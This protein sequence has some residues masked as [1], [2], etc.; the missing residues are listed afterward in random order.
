MSAFNRERTQARELLLKVGGVASRLETAELLATRAMALDPADADALALA[1]EADTR[2]ISGTI[3]QS[4][5]RIERARARAAKAVN[6]A[7]TAF[8]PRL[9]QAVF[10]VY[11][12]GQPMANNAEPDLIA[13]HAARPNEPRVLKTLAAL[14]RS[15]GRP[16][17]A[18]PYCD[19]WERIPGGAA[20]ALSQK[21]WALNQLRR[22]AEA[23][24]AADQS[25]ALQPYADNVALKV[26]LQMNWHGDLDGAL[27]TLRKMPAEDQLD[28]VGIAAAAKLYPWRREPANVLT[29][30]AAVP[31]DWITWSMW[32]PKAALIGD[33]HAE[34]RQGAAARA[35]WGAALQLIEARLTPDPNNR[36]LLVWQAYLKSELGD[37]VGARAAWR[38]ALE[39]PP[40]SVAILGIDKIQRLGSADELLD[41]LDRR[42][43][44]QGAFLSAAELRLNPAWDAVRALPRFRALAA[45]L[46]ADP[47][48]KAGRAAS[49]PVARAG[50]ADGGPS[51]GR[52]WDEV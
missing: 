5:E 21:A 30:L 44:G 26:Y 14:R 4:P 47:N 15:Q 28:D 11:A 40:A 39:L 8:E 45:R 20:G 10:L 6:L 17:D 33:A 49:R 9:A 3:D 29:V 16:R 27:A 43:E 32:A 51:S 23:E 1:S 2:T 37:V 7:P 50:P 36:K 24:T 12:L 42:S 34:L 25:I 13:L 19:E 41:S 46:N 38:R 31:R 52:L 22:L 35:D 18:L 48:F